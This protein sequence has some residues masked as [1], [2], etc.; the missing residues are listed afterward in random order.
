M[1]RKSVRM[2]L[3]LRL[4][5]GLKKKKRKSKHAVVKFYHSSDTFEKLVFLGLVYLVDAV[6]LFT[7]SM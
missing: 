5:D 1:I 7:Y 6:V 4:P 2:T 3:F